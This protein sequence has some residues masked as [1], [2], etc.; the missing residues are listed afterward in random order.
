[1]L[2][3]DEARSTCECG[4]S[5]TF[6]NGLNKHLRQ[7]CRIR[8]IYMEIE[9]LRKKCQGA[10]GETQLLNISDVVTELTK[11]TNSVRGVNLV[12]DSYSVTE[13]TMLQTAPAA[14]EFTDLVND[15]DSEHSDPGAS[16]FDM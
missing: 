8:E 1:M 6:R 5:F 9:Q 12:T 3:T 11:I 7:G 13:S 14:M 16:V 15:T 2:D 4:A 10:L